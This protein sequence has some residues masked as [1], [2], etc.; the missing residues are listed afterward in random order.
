MARGIEVSTP[1]QLKTLFEA[2]NSAPSWMSKRFIMTEL[3]GWS[4][5]LIAKNVELKNQEDQQ[6]KIGNKA[7]S[8]R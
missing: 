3:L 4:D 6:L 2:L 5:T 8:F 7:G 1:E